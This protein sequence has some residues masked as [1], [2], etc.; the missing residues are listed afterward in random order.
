MH[1]AI[2]LDKVSKGDESIH[3]VYSEIELGRARNSCL[4]G[5]IWRITVNSFTVHNVKDI[6]KPL[7]CVWWGWS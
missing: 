2:F 5:R 6:I 1:T 7:S 3:D 4:T